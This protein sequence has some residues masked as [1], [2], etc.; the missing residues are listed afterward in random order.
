MRHVS[1]DST[2]AADKVKV[3]IV[4]PS[5]GILGGQAVQASCLIDH[6]AKEPSFQVS[7]VPHNPRL[8][9][10]LRLLQRIKYV[11]T[12][13]TSLVYWAALLLKIPRHNIV[14]IFSASNFSFLLAPTPAIFISRLYGKKSILNYHSGE[15]ENHLRR[16]PRTAIPIMRLADQLVVPSQYLVDVFNRFGVKVHLIANTLD[17][18]SFKFRERR[19]LRPHFF[20]NRNLYPLYNVACVLRAFKIIQQTYPEAKLIVAGDGRQRA[21][22]ENLARKLKLRKTQF[23]GLVAPDQISK[24]YD[25][26]DIFLNSSNVDNLPGSILES[27]ASGLPIVTTSAGGIPYIVTHEQT[28]LLVPKNDAQAM[29]ASALRLLRSPELAETIARNAHEA[30]QIYRWSL[31]RD[32]WLSL[33]LRLARKDLKVDPSM[34]MECS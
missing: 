29:A 12:V 34:T 1:T 13:V 26:S 10:P 28:G 17:L 21:Y 2:D 19:P 11:R 15:A 4:A 3:L 25:E 14:H 20:S 6:L 24:L 22:L 8:P 30:C 23:L 33:Y 32:Q 9:G 18:D 31:V 16:W 27:Y 7:F 5:L